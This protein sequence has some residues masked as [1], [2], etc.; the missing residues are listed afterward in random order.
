MGEFY[1][2]FLSPGCG[3]E[4]SMFGMLVDMLGY[5][6]CGAWFAGFVLG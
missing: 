3:L 5:P 2:D 6:V 1:F 4:L